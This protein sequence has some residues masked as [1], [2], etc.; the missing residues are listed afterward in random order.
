L[1]NS[2][3]PLSAFSDA[4]VTLSSMTLTTLIIANGILGAALVAALLV[5]L[6]LGIHHDRRA[7]VALVSR[8]RAQREGAQDRLAA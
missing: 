8:P 2:E 1:G 7:R 4:R 6:G 5:H 3:V